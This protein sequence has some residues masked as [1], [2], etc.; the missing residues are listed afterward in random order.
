M[1]YSEIERHLCPYFSKIKA[2]RSRFFKRSKIT[3]TNLLVYLAVV[4]EIGGGV[5]GVSG[6]L[7][8]PELGREQ[9]GPRAGLQSKLSGFIV[10]EYAK[11]S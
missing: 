11:M 2:Q 9:I 1:F 3:L 4:D 10:V 8:R 6:R 5:G 7:V